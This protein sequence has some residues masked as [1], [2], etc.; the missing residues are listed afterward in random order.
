MGSSATHHYGVAATPPPLLPRLHGER[1]VE[2]LFLGEASRMGSTPPSK[3]ITVDTPFGPPSVA[4][5]MTASPFCK[6]AS[7]AAGM[8]PIICCR[9]PEPPPPGLPIPPDLPEPD[10]SEGGPLGFMVGL[11]LTAGPAAPVADADGCPSGGIPFM[12]MAIRCRI[13]PASLRYCDSSVLLTM[14]VSFS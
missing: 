10:L 1:I 13:G 4:T 8:R 3:V 14:T 2:G 9:S 7:V 6:S 11:A 5:T 12:R